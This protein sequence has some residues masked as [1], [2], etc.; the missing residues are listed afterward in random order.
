MDTYSPSNTYTE[1]ELQKLI[2][3]APGSL[4]PEDNKALLDRYSSDKSEANKVAF[5]Y[6][7]RF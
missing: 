7:A 3:T 5:M 4:T 6:S 1:E 2:R